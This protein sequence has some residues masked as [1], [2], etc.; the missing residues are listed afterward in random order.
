MDDRQGSGGPA[1]SRR[2]LVRSG[3][4]AGLVAAAGG[5]SLVLTRRGSD[6]GAGAAER[7]LLKASDL[8]SSVR[9]TQRPGERRTRDGGRAALVSLATPGVDLTESVVVFPT[10]EAARKSMNGLR[11]QA[12]RHGSMRTSG[13]MQGEV[14]ILHGPYHT[15]AFFRRG[16]AVIRLSLQGDTSEGTVARVL[17]R[18]RV[19]ASR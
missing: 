17:D 16:T 15:S 14:V 5:A 8:G 19:R 1:T 7:L 9:V 18:A 10:E 3:V 4:A 12:T 2:R 11:V 13:E 6:P